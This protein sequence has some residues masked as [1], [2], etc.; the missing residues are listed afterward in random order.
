MTGLKA[1]VFQPNPKAHGTY[2]KLYRL[3]RKLHDSFGTPQPNGSLYGVMKDLIL[4][5]NEVRA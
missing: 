5:R 4:I 2:K 3:Y 1:K